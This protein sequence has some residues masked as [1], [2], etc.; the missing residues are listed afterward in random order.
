MGRE[1]MLLMWGVASPL[2]SGKAKP[3]YPQLSIAMQVILETV[4]HLSAESLILHQQPNLTAKVLSFPTAV[5]ESAAS[6]KNSLP[7]PLPQGD[8]CGPM[9]LSSRAPGSRGQSWSAL[10]TLCSCSVAGQ[11]TGEWGSASVFS[12]D[13][14]GSLSEAPLSLFF[15]SRGLM[16]VGPSCCRWSLSLFYEPWGSVGG[17]GSVQ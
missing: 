13:R 7:I 9:R 2:R 5:T 8:L 4:G 11:V 6:L 17:D 3:S 1:Q 15:R 12:E 14:T 16:K 10:F